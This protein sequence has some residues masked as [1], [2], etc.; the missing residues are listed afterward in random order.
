MASPITADQLVSQLKKWK[1]R[2]REFP[3]WRTRGRPG[4]LGD[5]AGIVNHHTG[6]TGQSDDYLYFLFVTGRPESGIPGPLCQVATSANGTLNLGAIGRAN[7]AGSGSLSTMAHV[8]NEDYPGYSRE[9]SPGPDGINGNIYYYGNEIMYTGANPPTDAAYRTAVLYSAAVCDFHGWS[10]LAAI[11]H[12]EHTSRKNDPGNIP[13]NKFRTDLAT[14][15]R[16]GPNVTWVGK[17]PQAPVIIEEELPVSIA[18][19]ILAKL[20][21]HDSEEDNRYVRYETLFGRVMTKL[22]TVVTSLDAAV[23]AV[24]ARESETAAVG[25]YAHVI[26]TLTKWAEERDE[27]RQDELLAKL[28][29]LVVPPKA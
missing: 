25:R 8:R 4:G 17:T 12:R 21:S 7:H 28:N 19:D 11:A 10:A 14:V 13:M 9:I 20:N 16:V 29:G 27:I 26:E 6:G 3:G 23:A 22:E 15:L 18:E 5:M 24:N 1:V 2:Y